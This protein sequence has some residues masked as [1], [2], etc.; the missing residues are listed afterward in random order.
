MVNG[1]TSVGV[2]DSHH[3]TPYSGLQGAAGGPT[4]IVLSGTFSVNNPSGL[5][6]TE[7][8]GF[9]QYSGGTVQLTDVS[10][11]GSTATYTFILLTGTAPVVGT[12]ITVSGMSDSVNNTPVPTPGFWS[13]TATTAISYAVQAG[14]YDDGLITFTSGN[15]SG[16]SFQV[17]YWDGVTLTLSSALFAA[18]A[19]GDTF[20][21]SPGCDHT[22][23]TCVQKFNNIDNFRGFPSMPGQDAIMLYP[24]ATS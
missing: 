11:S 2:N 7:Q 21:I 12:H 22:V 3:I 15:N 4:N 13:V 18:C 24:D 16:L 20:V 19:D 14:Y 6:A 9:G 1:N 17:K 8:T 5:T 10:M 23:S